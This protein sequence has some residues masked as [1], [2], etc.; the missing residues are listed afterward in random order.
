MPEVDATLATARDEALAVRAM[1]ET[2]E[3]RFNGKTWSTHELQIGFANDVGQI[4]RLLL[5]EEGT[6]QIDGDPRAE[7]EHKLS[8]SM[9]W[10]FVIADRLGINMTEAFPETMG[11]IRAGLASTI[12]RTAPSESAHLSASDTPEQVSVPA[13]TYVAVAGSGAPGTEE[14]YRKKRLITQLAT[15]LS[16]SA[17]APV[18]ELQYWYPEDAAPVEIADFY[19][20]NP[21]PS[22]HYRVLALIPDATDDAQ[23][24]AAVER[25]ADPARPTDEI[26]ILHQ[27]EQEV[28]QVMHHGPFADEHATLAR[29]GAFAA[30]RGLRRRGPHHEIHLD[31]FGPETPQNDLRTILRDPVG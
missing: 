26:T 9:W 11:R 30:S 21:I 3:Q 8:E 4:G 17:T 22:L 6:W 16:P 5:A 29:L 7:L 19:L 28:V 23:L 31:A 1:Y 25:I 14:F 10:V 20:T 2:L 27:Q 18:V 13:A 15:E 12:A 24:A